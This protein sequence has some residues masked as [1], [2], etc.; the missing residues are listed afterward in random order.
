MITLLDSG[1]GALNVLSHC[2]KGQFN[3]ILD[4]EVSPYGEKSPAELEKRI[5]KLLEDY[6]E[7]LPVLACNTAGAVLPEFLSPIKFVQREILARYD[8]NILVIATSLTARLSPYKFP[9]TT[10]VPVDFVGKIERLEF[11]PF[12]L[13]AIEYYDTVVWGCTH[14]D[15]STISF[16]SVDREDIEHLSS[17]KI[18]AEHLPE[19]EGKKVRI[20]LVGEVTPSIELLTKKLRLQGW[21]IEN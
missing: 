21:E 13:P 5:R 8:K 15:L 17:A 11:I 20:T 12:N 10:V 16:P 4:T 2:K 7:G 9:N 3:V 18:L 14:Y 19:G 1:S 6:G